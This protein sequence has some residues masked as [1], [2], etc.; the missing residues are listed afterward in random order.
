M[1]GKRIKKVL[2]YSCYFATIRVAKGAVLIELILRDGVRG[3]EVVK[4][5]GPVLQILIDPKTPLETHLK[6][7]EGQL[8]SGILWY[9]SQLYSAD[10]APL[11]SI[12]ARNGSEAV[13]SANLNSIPTTDNL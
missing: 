7:N 12:N 11:R 5:I 8:L 4:Q 13:I 2:L 6:R 1:L 10:E 9:L 3:L